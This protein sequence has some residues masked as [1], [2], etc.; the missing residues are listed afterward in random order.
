MLAASSP[1]S[2]GAHALVMFFGATGG[3][4]GGAKMSTRTSGLTTFV[5]TKAYPAAGP[6]AVAPS[7]STD[8]S[9]AAELVP[10]AGVKP[11]TTKQSSGRWSF[12]K[13]RDTENVPPTLTGVGVSASPDAGA[14]TGLALCIWYVYIYE[15]ERGDWG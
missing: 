9:T 3:G 11:P 8:A 7:T 5:L 13:K 10:A 1:P 15:T 2:A 14:D 12:W 6:G 4:L